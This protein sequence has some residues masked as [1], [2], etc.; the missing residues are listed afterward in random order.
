MAEPPEGR[1]RPG[2][3]GDLDG[4]SRADLVWTGTRDPGDPRRARLYVAAGDGHGG[5]G[6]AREIVWESG[7][8][9]DDGGLPV[10]ADFDGD[11]HADVLVGLSFGFS[12]SGF[13]RLF[14]GD[15]SGGLVDG[16]TFGH[17]GSIVGL[18][19]VDL[20]R[21]GH[22]EIVRGARFRVGGGLVSVISGSV[23][24]FRPTSFLETG[25]GLN[26]I[27]P[28]DVN[29]D[30]WL[31]LALR[32]TDAYSPEPSGRLRVVLATPA[33]D[34]VRAGEDL[35][36]IGAFVLADLEGSGRAGVFLVLREGTED[37]L[38]FHRSVCVDESSQLVLPV[39]VR[40][41][42]ATG[43]RFD[44]E[45]TLLNT[46][47]GEA[48]VEIRD[49][50]SWDG[51]PLRTIVLG[52]SKV[53]TLST[54]GE[55]G[56]LLALASAAGPLRLDVRGIPASQLLA[57]ARVLSTTPGLT[58]RGTLGIEAYEPAASPA[59]V[60]WVPWLVEDDGDRSN[61]AVLNPGS[62]AEGDV[63]VRVTVVSTD[64]KAPG[65]ATLDDATLPPGGFR[66][67]NRVLRAAGLAARTGFARLERVS[68]AGR[69]DGY[70]VLNDAVSSDG[71]FPAHAA[72]R[73]GLGPVPPRTPRSG[74]AL[75]R[76][77]RDRASPL[78]RGRRAARRR[79]AVL[80]GRGGR[81]RKDVRSSTSPHGAQCESR[82]SWSMS[83]PLPK[84]GRE[85]ARC[86]GRSSRGAR[87]RAS[88]PSPA[89]GPAVRGGA[90]ESPPWPRR[91]TAGSARR[92]SSPR[93]SRTASRARTSRSSSPRTT[94]GSAPRSDS[95]SSTPK[96][97]LRRRRTSTSERRS[98]RS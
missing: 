45:L 8:D 62:P 16:E 2:A 92:A 71:S 94:R 31:D 41:V 20:D 24:G 19:A 18:S 13:L 75:D 78:Q 50:A 87:S 57:A 28:G 37:R 96:G 33:G 98:G 30:G 5:F 89:R 46:G 70:A 29:G 55:G 59:G 84:G 49:G 67:W 47:A 22:P 73:V 6:P 34:L 21:D 65:E 63:T 85:G 68:A 79:A 72:R 48:R 61:L 83:A 39:A 44:T 60:S 56:K 36:L 17:G 32:F 3:L 7:V 53:V 26:V 66:Q 27:Q 88:W 91:R 90:T 93:Q 58:G 86:G 38:V 81:G 43:A 52:P 35:P 64:P 82:T 80:P 9:A 23:E 51:E 95:G 15:G 97:G 69:Y 1:C 10:V 76:P 4:D 74:R 14:R 12:P 11:G 42:G 54:A 77:L 25:T 40:T